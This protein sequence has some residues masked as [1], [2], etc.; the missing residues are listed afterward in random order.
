MQGESATDQ[1]LCAVFHRLECVVCESAASQCSDYSACGL[2]LLTVRRT[3]PCSGSQ[4]RF[5][6]GAC[7]E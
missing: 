4:T 5:V 6:G 7:V 1:V 2:V 3:R